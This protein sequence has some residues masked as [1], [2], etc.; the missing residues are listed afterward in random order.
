MQ[1]TNNSLP[2]SATKVKTSRTMQNTAL[3]TL[4]D[5]KGMKER[6]QTG[7]L[8]EEQERRLR[9]KTELKDISDARVKNWPNTIQALRKKKDDA[10]FERFQKEEEERRKIDLEEA[11][12]QAGVKQ[13]ILGKANKQV[14]ETNDRVKAFQ[15]ALLLSDAL[16]EREAQVAINKRRKEID[17][18]IEERYVDMDKQT[19]KEFDEREV[20]KVRLEEL[21]RQEQQKVLKEQHD[22]FKLKNIKKMQEEKIEGEIIKIKTQEALEREREEERKRKQKLLDTQEEIKLGNELLQEIRHQEKLKEMQ[23]D[24]EIAAFAKKKEEIMEMRK[25]R[26]DLKFKERQDARQKIID[27]Q[28]IQLKLLK[29]KEDEILN[30]NIK[31]AEIKA[32]ENERIKKEK[33]EQLVKEID[34]QITLTLEKR[35]VEKDKKKVE[36][37]NFQEFWKN[38]NKELEEKENTDKEAFKARCKNLQEFHNKQAGQ[39]QKQMETDMLKEFDDALKMKA[40]MELEEKTFQSY[41]QKCLVEWDDNGKNVKPLLLELQRYKKKTQ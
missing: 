20:E 2:H 22:Q 19:M 35:R 13:E 4:S 39:K 11:I 40:A 28:I 37:K 16:K 3:L 8:N 23:K 7:P 29:N 25:L 33:R 30:K 21:K 36:D 27:T 12:F 17:V 31:E 26:E 10:R 41:A 38:K 1:H 32:E 9:D 14:Y 18:M 5:Y 24:R 34:S 6:A 15:S